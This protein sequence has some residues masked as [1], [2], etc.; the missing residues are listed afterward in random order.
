MSCSRV[1]RH[2]LVHYKSIK[3]VCHSST[4]AEVSAGFLA[5][6]A[7]AYL[8]EIAISPLET[9]FTVKGSIILL[10]DREAAIVIS[11]N[12]GTTKRT[13]HFFYAGIQHYLRW[14]VRHN[15]ITV[16]FVKGKCQ[17]ADTDS[18]TKAIDIRTR[19][20]VLSGR[21]CTGPNRHYMEHLRL[22]GLTVPPTGVEHECML[23]RSCRHH[24]GV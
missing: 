20:S 14:C 6:K 1:G 24:R 23:D 3:V 21:F 9:G 4:E 16:A 22:S 2:R 17:L 7:L 15:Y 19:R 10:R 12:L 11:Q 5:A 8:R 18:L 13:A